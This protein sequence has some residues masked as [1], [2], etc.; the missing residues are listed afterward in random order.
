MHLDS[1]APGPLA[2]ATGRIVEALDPAAVLLFGSQAA[3]RG[4]PLSDHDFAVLSAG[5]RP[6][7]EEVRRLQSDLEDILGTEVDIVVLDDASP[8]VA[9]QAFREGRLLACRDAQSLEN[10]VVR[11]LTDYADLKITRAPIERRLMETG[12]R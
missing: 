10:F 8:V 1:P 4:G 2:V 3:G 5:T 7:W 6:G 11:T 9:M 12:P